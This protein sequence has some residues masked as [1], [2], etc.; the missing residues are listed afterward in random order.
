M[1]TI[2]LLQWLLL[3]FGSLLSKSWNLAAGIYTQSTTT[4]T[5]LPCLG[6]A[7]LHFGSASQ[8]R[9]AVSTL[10]VWEHLSFVALS[11]QRKRSKNSIV[12]A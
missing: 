3:F 12:D 2:L 4:T 10:D 8:T 1:D 9:E 6:R 5:P 7:A 11:T